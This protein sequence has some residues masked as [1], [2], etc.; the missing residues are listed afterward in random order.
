[1]ITINP[2][3]E[4]DSATVAQ[5]WNHMIGIPDSCWYQSTEATAEWI[6]SLES[7]GLV[8]ALAT[9]GGDAVGFG[10]WWPA[11][12]SMRLGALA[13]ETAEVYF[14]LMVAFADW[15]LANGRSQGSAEIGTRQTNEKGWM[16]SLSVVT[17]EPI[18]FMPIRADEDPAGRVPAV[19]RVTADLQ[20]L[21]TAA[22]AAAGDA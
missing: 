20:A 12:D 15:G 3:S 16:D 7:G 1:M 5:L 6:T 22:A 19:L 18:G 21:K 13:G 8:F 14:S 9:S 2:C 4:S 10:F 11:D 17:T